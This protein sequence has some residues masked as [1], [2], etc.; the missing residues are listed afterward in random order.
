MPSHSAVST[1]NA[2]GSRAVA[3][4]EEVKAAADASGVDML[5]TH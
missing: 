5:Y 3:K 2:N 1:A 4:L